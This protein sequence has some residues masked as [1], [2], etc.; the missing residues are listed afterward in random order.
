MK[1]SVGA[2]HRPGDAQLAQRAVEPVDVRRLV[3][4]LAVAHADD[5]VDAVGEL[6]A[7]ILD[8][9]AGLAMLDIASVDVGV[10]RHEPLPPVTRRRLAGGALVG[11]A[12]MQPERLQLAVQRR[13]L[14]ADEG[15]GA[16]DVA[17]EARDLGQQIFA[18]ED[19][20][21]IAQRQLHDL[22][23]LLPAQHRRR[24]L[25]D[26][27]GQHVGADRPAARR[28]Q[29]QQPLDDVAQLADVARPVVALQRGQRVLAD[30]RAS[31]GRWRRRRGAAGRSASSGMSS[32]RSLSGGTRS[33][34]TFSRW[35]SSS[36]KRPAAISSCSSRAGRGEHAHVDLDRA[37]CRRRA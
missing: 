23:A 26:V 6:V 7:A 2:R 24:I 33:G 20:A 10:T 13:A 32:R 21:R 34:T 17:A 36:R 22:A 8:M 27:V 29:D 5:L 11:R 18:L 14:H 19:L 28:R 35:K 3:D 37:S 4:Q 30:R 15:R 12:A 1:P 16:R 9:D 25:A 31:A